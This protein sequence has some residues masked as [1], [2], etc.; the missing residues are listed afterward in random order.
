MKKVFKSNNICLVFS[1]IIFSFLLIKVLFAD[2]LPFNSLLTG[3]DNL[4]EG[5]DIGKFTLTWIPGDTNSTGI[6]D[7]EDSSI[8]LLSPNTNSIY[9]AESNTSGGGKVTYQIMFNMGG[10]I[11]APPGSIIIK[12]PKYIFYDREN[13]PAEQIIDVPLAEY[14]NSQGTGFN[15]RYETD[16]VTGIE[17]LVLENYQSIPE[18]YSFEASISWILKTPSV[19]ADNYQ[20]EIHGVVDVDFDLDGTSEL[21]SDSN[22][23]K[24][25]YSSHAAIR[26]LAERYN[27]HTED[28]LP[29]DTNIYLSWNNA[30]NSELKPENPDDYIYMISYAYSTVYYATQPYSLQFRVY[31][32]DENEGVVLGYCSNSTCSSSATITHDYCS[33]SRETPSSSY[34]SYSVCSFII[35]YPKTK[36][37]ENVSHTISNKLTED[38]IGVDGATDY[39]EA[40]YSKTFTIEE[41]EV[42]SPTDNYVYLSNVIPNPSQTVT[43]SRQSSYTT[44]QG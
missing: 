25:Q 20:K 17:Y 21:H 15:Y 6:L 16:S 28:R 34:N 29:P 14:P 3:P 43:K 30:W 31:P 39:K 10:N 22:I 36:I 8:I 4:N 37:T 26:S 33:V 9:N 44:V 1:V 41:Q 42:V 5:N 18:S 38:L 27:T 35:K 7:Q 12:L 19:V 2:F 24:L 40:T 11:A 13:N 32:T 23:I